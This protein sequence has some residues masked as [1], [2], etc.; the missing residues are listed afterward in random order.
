MG[1]RFL[2]G[3]VALLLLTAMSPILV[4]PIL[5][6]KSKQKARKELSGIS[7]SRRRVFHHEGE[8]NA[9]LKLTSDDE[10]D[11]FI[12]QYNTLQAL[13]RMLL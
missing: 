3:F 10:W 13:F 11:Q 8:L 6:Q 5:A 12:Q 9:F 1:G 2:H 4:R 7:G